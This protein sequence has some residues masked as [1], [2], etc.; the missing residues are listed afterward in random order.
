MTSNFE[1][2]SDAIDLLMVAG[3]PC[4]KIYNMKDIDEDPHFN[5]CGWIADMPMADGMTTVRT[6]RFPSDPFKFSA[7]EPVYGKAPALGE[8]NHEV[9]EALGFTAEE[10]DE[11]EAEWE[12]K[13]KNK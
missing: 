1:Q 4:S 5:Q 11:M 7:F 6:R 12:M 13:V 9:L 3:V 10:V 8:Q 2:V